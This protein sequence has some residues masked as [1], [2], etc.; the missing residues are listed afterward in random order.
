MSPPRDANLSEAAR[1]RARADECDQKA[2]E[3]K[4]AEAKRLL[5]DAAQEWR[6]LAAQVERLRW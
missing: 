1:L 5:M 6:S 2:K 3:A 4:D